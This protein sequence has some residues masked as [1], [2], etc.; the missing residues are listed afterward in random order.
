MSNAPTLRETPNG[1]LALSPEADDVH[2]GVP[3]LTEEEARA[4][5]AERRTYW[6]ELRSRPIVAALADDGG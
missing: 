3:G 1:W 4:N 5:Y 2:I 6:L